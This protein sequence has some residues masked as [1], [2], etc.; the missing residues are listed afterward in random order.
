[1]SDPLVKLMVELASVRLAADEA[2]K[3]SRRDHVLRQIKSVRNNLKDLVEG[4]ASIAAGV[5]R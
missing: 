4:E 3:D 2:L 1:M 5:H